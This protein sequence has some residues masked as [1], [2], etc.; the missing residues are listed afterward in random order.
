[1]LQTSPAPQTVDRWK[2]AYQR[3]CLEIDRNRLPQRISDA[4]CAIFDRAE[5][6]M[7][8]PAST[9][10]RALNNALRAL[11]VLEE[12]LTQDKPAA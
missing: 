4:R 8:Q 12:Q 11:R 9:E 7:T 10:H 5:E 1:M 2:I 6:M 3:A